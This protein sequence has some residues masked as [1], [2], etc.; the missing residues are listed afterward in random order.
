MEMIRAERLQSRRRRAF[1]IMPLSL[2]LMLTGVIRATGHVMDGATMRHFEIFE[3][4]CFLFFLGAFAFLIAGR[5]MGRWARP[6]LDD[7]VS[8]AFRGRALQFG[9]FILLPGVA[10]LYVVGLFSREL[11][12]ELAPV[13]A[14]L[15]ICGPAVRLYLLERSAATDDI[16]A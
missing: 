12:V 16:D 1:L 11:A 7:E 9:Y 2:I 14:A 13:L 6:V 15:G 4:G 5:G 3:V 10:A 8:R